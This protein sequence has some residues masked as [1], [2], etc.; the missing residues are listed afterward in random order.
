MVPS[1]AGPFPITYKYNHVEIMYY[2]F[3]QSAYYVHED[4]LY[5]NYV[6]DTFKYSVYYT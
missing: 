6:L 3:K 2:T 4:I 5:L 1:C